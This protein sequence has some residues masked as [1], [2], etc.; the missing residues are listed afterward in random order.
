MNGLG[1]A[2]RAAAV[3]KSG[4]RSCAARKRRSGERGGHLSRLQ[5][6]VGLLAEE[7]EEEERG[8]KK[9][10]PSRIPRRRG[11]S[12]LRRWP[13]DGSGED[14]LGRF[15]LRVGTAQLGL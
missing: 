7:E 3:D 9:R 15:C 12:L 5:V 4:A 1:A 6:G 11:I 2:G 10:G 8:E 13:L 14:G